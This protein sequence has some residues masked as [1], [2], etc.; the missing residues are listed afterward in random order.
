MI[1]HPAGK[2]I[3]ATSAPGS[4]PPGDPSS[5]GSEVVRK[6]DRVADHYQRLGHNRSRHDT[7]PKDAV[8]AEEVAAREAALVSLPC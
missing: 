6:H 8:S 5:Q 1:D 7:T 4:P 3:N 2:I